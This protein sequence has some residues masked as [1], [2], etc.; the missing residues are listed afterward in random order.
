M[1]LECSNY[2]PVISLKEL[3]TPTISINKDMIDLDRKRLAR[4]AKINYKSKVACQAMTHPEFFFR[5]IGRNL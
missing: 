4:R 5:C 3:S 2:K 1:K